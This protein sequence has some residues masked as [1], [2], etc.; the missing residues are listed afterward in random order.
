MVVFSN[1]GTGA[2]ARIG[3][4]PGFST[5][6]DRPQL[7]QTREQTR[8]MRPLPFEKVGFPIPLLNLEIFSAIN[9]ISWLSL[10]L[11]IKGDRQKES[12]QAAATSLTSICTAYKSCLNNYRKKSSAN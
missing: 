10:N 12:P 8:L 3:K 4:K 2:I 7:S 5:A 11:L 6:I 1:I 9:L